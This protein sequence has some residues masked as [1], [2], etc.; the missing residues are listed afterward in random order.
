MSIIASLLLLGSGLY[1]LF[2]V[3]AP[4]L[5]PY[6]TPPID[7]KALPT[8]SYDANRL[9]I[10]KISV[11]I[12]YAPGESSLESGA[13]WRYPE[14]GSPTTGGNFILAAHRFTIWS[15]PQETIIK[16]P[17]YRV[18]KLAVGDQMLVDYK[19]KRYVYEINNI[20]NVKPTQVEIEAP[21]DTPKM[22]LY[23]C[24]LG[25]ASDGRVVLTATPKG[26]YDPKS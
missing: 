15:T 16:S 8:P 1:L 25:G 6:F 13:W 19:G 17:F 18:D 22:T 12:A 14:R 21:S 20:T 2:L 26:E 5:V 9:I 4:A 10:P 11:N 24:S 23:T 7:V 3:S